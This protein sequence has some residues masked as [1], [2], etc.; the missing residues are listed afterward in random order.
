M[1]A[2]GV[3]RRRWP[4]PARTATIASLSILSLHG[5]FPTNDA[6]NANAPQAAITATTQQSRFHTETLE[7]VAQVLPNCCLGGWLACTG[8]SKDAGITQDWSAC[9]GC[10]LPTRIL[11]CR[12][13]NLHQLRGHGSCC[14]NPPSCLLPISSGVR[15]VTSHPA[16]RQDVDL[17]QLHLAVGDRE[18]LADAHLRLFAGRRYALVG[19]C[20]AV[21]VWCCLLGSALQ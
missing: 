8:C 16:S 17:R 11:H 4:A 21:T 1:A 15:P 18:L 20:A 3:G 10:K 13:I 2:G 14:H 6:S 7:A 9:G 19:R 5:T 12:G